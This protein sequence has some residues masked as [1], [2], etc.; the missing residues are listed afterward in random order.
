MRASVVYKFSC[1]Q[2][3][4][5]Y[6]GSTTHSLYRRVA[7]HSGR[8]FRTNRLLT[9]PPHSNIRDHTFNCH[10]PITLENFTILN[11]CKSETDLHI[12]ESLYIYKTNPV[13]N[14]FNWLLLNNLKWNS[15]LWSFRFYSFY[16]Y[17]CVFTSIYIYTRNSSKVF[18]SWKAS[19]FLC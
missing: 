3:T 17:I 16:V 7:Q 6:V 9:T 13:L 18:P 12:L 8:S 11:S 5:E 2:C 15:S 19:K 14:V 4:S 1:V 10:S